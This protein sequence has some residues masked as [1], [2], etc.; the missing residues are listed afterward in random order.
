MAN[1]A[2]LNAFTAALEAW[3]A[4]MIACGRPVPKTGELRYNFAGRRYRAEWKVGRKPRIFEISLYGRYVATGL[5][6]ER[7]VF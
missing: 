1:D 7:R 5:P 2:F 3:E 6:T 4:K